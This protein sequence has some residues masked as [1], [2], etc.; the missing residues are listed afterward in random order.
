MV[1]NLGECP[2]YR[3]HTN[4]RQGMNQEL[5]NNRSSQLKRKWRRRDVIWWRAIFVEEN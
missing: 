1:D 4:G 3:I 2:R 5:R